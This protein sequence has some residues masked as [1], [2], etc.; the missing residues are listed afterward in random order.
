MLGFLGS[1][2]TRLNCVNWTEG[3]TGVNVRPPSELSCSP[4]MLIEYKVFGLFGA[5]ARSSVLSTS[6]AAPAVKVFP[7]SREMNNPLGVPRIH[8][9]FEPN[10]TAITGASNWLGGATTFSVVQVCPESV[11]RINEFGIPFPPPKLAYT[12]PA[13]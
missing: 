4:E 5:I 1:T 6:T 9:P 7:P 3:N 10:R 13:C 8:A 12:V 2:A 11:L